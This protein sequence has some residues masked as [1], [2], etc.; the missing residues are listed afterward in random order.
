MLN[1]MNAKKWKH[2]ASNKKIETWIPWYKK[3]F[4][5]FFFN[6]VWRRPFRDPRSPFAHI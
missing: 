4:K 2:P 6:V 1:V 3:E 5:D